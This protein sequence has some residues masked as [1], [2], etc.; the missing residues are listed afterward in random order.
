MVVRQA[1]FPVPGED[2]PRGI[3]LVFCGRYLAKGQLISCCYGRARLPKFAPARRN[4]L[5]NIRTLPPCADF[6]ER[7]L[8][9]L[10]FRTKML[11]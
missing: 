7:S 1:M 5:R 4:G 10:F 8:A 11:K 3:G 6:G 9:L 2:G